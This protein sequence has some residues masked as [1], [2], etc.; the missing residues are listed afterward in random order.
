MIPKGLEGIDQIRQTALS[1]L[2]PGVEDAYMAANIHYLCQLLDAVAVD[3]DRAAD[4]LVREL[5]ELKEIFEVA[6][7]HVVEDQLRARLSAAASTEN[8][9]LR[10]SDL[11][12]RSDEALRVLIDLHEV[13][14]NAR[15]EGAQWADELDR[16]IWRFL[17]GYVER[18]EFRS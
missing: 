5:G 15:E 13:V 6:R 1:V 16:L 14:E 4:N 12:E 11:S 9:S 2:L 3:Y 8:K 10:V 7:R 18:R 17:E